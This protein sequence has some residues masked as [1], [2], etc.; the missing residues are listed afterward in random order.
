MSLTDTIKELKDQIAEEEKKEIDVVEE[1]D[2]P[3]EEVKEEAKEEVKEE[4]KEEKPEEEE[5]LDNNGYRKLRREAAAA[6]KLAEDREAEIAE[7]KSKLSS[8]KEEEQVETVAAVDP[9]IQEVVRDHRMRNAEKEF[10]TLEAKFRSST[11]EYDAVSNE[12]ALAL[13]QSI[14][15]QNPRLSA[16]EIAEKTKK[17]I[18]F[19]ASE[20]VQQGFD[21]IEELFHEAKELGFTGKK[22]EE[23]KTEEEIKP[24]MKKVAE[25]RK[26]STGMTGSNGKSEGQVTKQAA[27]DFT[28]AE[29]K[30]LPASEKRRLMYG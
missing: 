6:K 20:W 17:T 16:T 2:Q 19:K 18:L 22:R 27:S 25:N 1:E 7:L 9:E 8:P 3:E 4:P 29:W 26:K 23:P 14:K 11:P 15:I 21:P 24:D 13:A 5:K 10:Q 30:S 12:Y 28:V